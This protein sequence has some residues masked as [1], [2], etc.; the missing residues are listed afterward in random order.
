MS[1]FNEDYLLYRQNLE[2]TSTIFNNNNNFNLFP[3]RGLD[4]HSSSKL[5]F[6]TKNVNSKANF[7]KNNHKIKIKIIVFIYQQIQ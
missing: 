2:S 1:F 6:K 7:P 3:L 5:N 4:Y